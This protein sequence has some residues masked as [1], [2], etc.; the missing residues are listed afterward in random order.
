VD[1]VEENNVVTMLADWT[2]RDEAIGDK[3][4]DLKSNSI[5]LM[6]I[7]PPGSDSKPIVLRDIL[8]ESTVLKALEQA[9]PSVGPERLTSTPISP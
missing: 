6:A 2:S 1:K 3:L 7:Y 8:S 9:G 5:P 4:K